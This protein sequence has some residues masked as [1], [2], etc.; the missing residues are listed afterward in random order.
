MRCLSSSFYSFLCSKVKNMQS[1]FKVLIASMLMVASFASLAQ[2]TLNSADLVVIHRNTDLD[3]EFALL[4]LADIPAN[5]IVFISDEGWDDFD[6]TFDGN[7]DAFAWT[8]P[9]GGI[10]AGTIVKFTNEFTT[11]LSLQNNAH[12]T[13]AQSNGSSDLN[14]SAGDQLFIYQTN[15]N[16]YDGTIERLNGLGG[17]EAGMIYA[18]N[19]DNSAPNT[20]GWLDPGNGHTSAASQLPDNMTALATS[21]GSGNASIAN[22]NGMLTQANVYVSNSSPDPDGLATDEY[23]NY[24]YNGPTAA[25]PKTEWLQRIHTTANWF[26]S[27]A[28]VFASPVYGD[29]GVPLPPSFTVV[30]ANDAPLIANFGGDIID[31]YQ[32]EVNVILDQNV[33]VTVT[34]SDSTDLDGGNLTLTITAGEDASEDLLSLD[35][36]GLISLSGTTAGSNVSVSPRGVIGTLGNNIAAGNDLVINFNSNARAEEAQVIA[37]LLTYQNTDTS[38]ATSGARNIRLTVNDGDGG[39]SL[40]GDVT[41]TVVA[42]PTV[43]SATYNA[44]TNIL[45]VTGTNFITATGDDVDVTKLT[46]KGLAGGSHTLVAGQTANVAAIDSATAFSVTVAG[47]DIAAVEALLDYNGTL[48]SDG[49]NYYSMD[50]AD[51]FLLGFLVGDTA[52]PINGVTVTGW[53]VPYVTSATFDATAGVLV[54]SGGDFVANGAGSDIDVSLISFLAEGNLTHTLTDSADVEIDSATQFTVVLSVA[55]LAALNA[56]IN[57]NGTVA[58][59]GAVY[60]IS[61]ADDFVTAITNGNTADATGNPITVSNVPIPAITSATYD[62]LTGVLVATGTNIP[63]VAGLLN[64]IDASL[65]TFTGD[66]GATYTLVGTGDVERTSATEFSFTLDVTDK[67]AV[68]TLLN[69]NGVSA[70]DAT[71]YNLHAAE[72]WATGSDAAANIIDATTPITVANVALPAITSATYNVSTG[73]LSVTSTNLLA[74]SGAA[75]DIDLSA[76][77]ITGQGGSTHTL[78]TATDI[79][80]TSLTSFST[81]LLGADKTAVEAL[82]NLNGTQSDDATTYN[83]AAAD[84]WNRGAGAAEDISDATNP[85]T[86]VGWPVPTITS[87]AYDAALGNLVVTGTNFVANS[88]A[89]NDIDVSLLSILGY[90]NGTYSFT[91]L[92]DVEIDSATQFTLTLSGAE[93]VEVDKLLNKNGTISKDVVFYK[94]H[95]ADD[96]LQAITAGDTADVDNTIS[97]INADITPPVLPIVT[98]PSS[99]VTTQQTNYT[100]SGTHSENGVTIGIYLDADNNN[101]P[102]NNVAIISSVVSGNSWSLVT[103]LATVADHNFVIVAR[104]AVLNQSPWVNVP[105]ITREA[106]PVVVPPPV[107]TP[108]PIVNTPPTGA[109]LI[110]GKAEVGQTLNASHSIVDVDGLGDITYRW[111]RDGA[112]V[113]SGTSYVLEAADLNAVFVVRAEYT[114]NNGTAES[115]SSEATSKVVAVKVAPVANDMTVSVLEDASASVVLTATGSA[116]AKLSYS[117]KTQPQNGQLTGQIPNLTY[118]PNANVNGQDSFVFTVSDGDLTSEGTVKVTISPVND[119]PVARNDVVTVTSWEPILID[120]L[121]NDSDIDNADLMIVSASVDIGSVAIIGN[122]L[123]FTPNNGFNGNAL[124]NYTVNDSDGA[125]ASAQVTVVVDVESDASIEI[126]PPLDIIIEADALFTRVDLGVAVAVD[127]QGAPLPVSLLNER[128]HFEPGLHKVIWQSTDAQG[129]TIQAVQQVQVNPM[130]SFGKNQT[131]ME[132]ASVSVGVYLNG[133]SPVYPLEISYSVAGSADNTDHDLVEG[134][135]TIE[136]GTSGTIEF[137]TLTDAVNDSNEVIIISLTEDNNASAQSSLEV[138]IS[139]Q[140]V[141]PDLSLVAKQ[142]GEPRAIVN[143]QDGDV[144]ILATIVSADSTAQYSYEWLA[145]DTELVG[146]TSGDSFSFDPQSIEPG[147]YLVS[148]AIRHVDSDTIVASQQ[149]RFVLEQVA[150][151]LTQQDTDKDGI[152]DQIEGLIDTDNDGIPQYLDAIDECNVL[153][154][155]LADDTQFLIESTPGVCLRLGD[156]TIGGESGGAQLLE[157]LVDDEAENHGGIFDFIANGLPVVG[158]SVA[159]VIPQRQ[160]IPANAIYRKL[161]PVTGWVN[162]HEGANDSVWSAPGELGYCPAPG[163]EKW[164]NGLTEGHWC[165]QLII[166]DGGLND[167]DGIENG[168]IVDPGGVAVLPSSNIAPQAND[169]SINIRINDLITVDVLAND[170]DENNDVLSITSAQAVYGVVSIVD[171]KLNYQP[172]PQYYGDDTITYAVSDGKGG[173]SIAKVTVAIAPNQAPVSQ[174]DVAVVTAGQ[175]VTINVLAND[176]DSDG[177]KLYV[178]DASAERGNVVINGDESLTYIAPADFS[179]N[180]V[181]SYQIRDTQGAMAS[182]Q[183]IVTVKAVVIVPDQVDSNTKGGAL[184]FA[185]LILLMLIGGRGRNYLQS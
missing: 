51:D 64:D 126:T 61:F 185:L 127:G 33:A 1:V 25:A 180:D 172:A 184:Y 96:Y 49:V 143:Q 109:V 3:D 8:I 155:Q 136:S 98:T 114:D 99:A 84:N 46:L 150:V 34:D 153:P 151:E 103:P 32:G 175:Q 73:L 88:G 76:L 176:S 128:T 17:V 145:A 104:D 54:V 137:N 148:L 86:V 35:T 134:V 130:V 102:D 56:M 169:D 57:K 21:D 166:K 45:A 15:D 111:L 78:I 139:E 177:D 6:F 161:M 119:A 20:N 87:A 105:T 62:A 31:Y 110:S 129:R 162:F 77:T 66:G 118:T 60:N 85:I 95:A 2:A 168:S 171:N 82:L 39:I 122:K 146:I 140:F 160:P 18:F 53:P 125:S 132:G 9:V 154:Q 94:L 68:N 156:E 101:S 81:T 55:D 159:I 23:D 165:V 72:D 107:V 163:D 69:S 40:N 83:L 135:V 108:P 38:S 16:L 142:A 170:S 106:A 11:T 58:T 117:L 141:A 47:T 138:L 164:Q 149:I 44:A 178:Y 120:V 157:S 115:V 90:A 42:K 93:K 71:I 50:V 92:T 173:N 14:L 124:I 43:S 19:G 24:I 37:R 22:A 52:D 26:A 4:A 29:G 144:T 113:A 183:V 30:P 182:A 179:G 5:S 70:T 63:L 41:L 75:N 97:V 74:L 48:S 12:G 13:I 174:D 147:V 167:A 123:S 158:Q 89:A 65:F 131:V 80:I 79:E 36:S 10:A 59:G 91:S 116:D 28:N 181:V 100:V 133:P 121:A 7:E 112:N 67:A 152:P 27:D